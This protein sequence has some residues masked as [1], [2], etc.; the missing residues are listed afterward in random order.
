MRT[1]HFNVIGT[2]LAVSLILFTSTPKASAAY[3]IL[4]DFETYFV[5]DDITDQP[6]WSALAAPGSAAIA[7]DPADCCRLWRRSQVGRGT[8]GAIEEW[9]RATRARYS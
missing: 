1:L 6:F 5:D 3:T 4:D 2:V 7:T 9:R 8:R